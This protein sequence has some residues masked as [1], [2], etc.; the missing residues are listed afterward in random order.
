MSDARR[1]PLVLFDLDGT[2]VDT[3]GAGRTAI[4]RAFGAVL[5]RDGIDSKALG[6]RFAGSSDLRIFAHLALALE[7]GEGWAAAHEPALVQHYLAALDLE[8]SRPDPRRRVLPGVRELLE[9]LSAAGIH[10]GLL[11]GNIE[12]GARRKLEPFGLN[13]FFP[14]G[15]FGSDS[16]DRRE[17][18]RIAHRRL[19]ALAGR[20][21][22]PD[23]VV[24]VG[25]TEQDVDCARA[26]GFRAVAVESGWVSRAAL[27][28]AASTGMPAA[29]AASLSRR[30]SPT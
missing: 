5:G 21:Y 3:A 23:D 13:P 2:L 22:A 26:N 15:G 11:T 20:D 12:A 4:E 18:A 27:E 9:A 17:I 24:V 10:V 14:G 7:L 29:R 1:R 16:A 8:L 28:A 6:V 30:S 25:D 19:A